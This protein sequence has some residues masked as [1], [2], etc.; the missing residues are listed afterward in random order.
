[1]KSSLHQLLIARSKRIEAEDGESTFSASQ[2]TSRNPSIFIGN[3]QDARDIVMLSK[4][5]ITHVL[6]VAGLH[7]YDE[8]P[9]FIKHFVVN[10]ADHPSSNILEILPTCQNFIEGCLQNEGVILI[11]C[12]SGISRS[13]TVC[14]MYLM[15]KYEINGTDALSIIRESRPYANPNVGFQYQISLLESKNQDIHTACA[16][17]KSQN[18]EDGILYSIVERRSLANELHAKVDSLEV[19]IKSFSRFTTEESDELQVQLSS[20]KENIMRAG[21]DH[22]SGEDRTFIIHDKVASMILRS[23]QSKCTRLLEDVRLMVHDV[24]DS[25]GLIVPHVSVDVGLMSCQGEYDAEL[26]GHHVEVDA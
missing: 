12:A 1:M 2:L 24:V 18:I 6:T 25:V 4:L 11:H 7:V 13:V 3:L 17:F 9:A 22:E 21:H 16:I 26:T 10:I 23:A 20:I 15:C 14:A 5:G 19:T 8:T